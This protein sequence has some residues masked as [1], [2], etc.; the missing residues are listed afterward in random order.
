MPSLCLCLLLLLS[1]TCISA[2][3]HKGGGLQVGDVAGTGANHHG[4]K[5]LFLS[6]SNNDSDSG[7]VK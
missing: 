2:C 1:L 4:R 5:T 3:L 7:V 6:S